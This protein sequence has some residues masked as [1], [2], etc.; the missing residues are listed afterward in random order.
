ML[1]KMARK[2]KPSTRKMEIDERLE[3]H[4][5]RI[6]EDINLVEERDERVEEVLLNLLSKFQ[7]FQDPRSLKSTNIDAMT[8][9]MDLYTSLPAKRAQLRKTII[10]T[11][12]KKQDL[13]QRKEESEDLKDTVSITMS[14][15][16]GM[17]EKS[18]NCFPSYEDDDQ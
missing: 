7:S 18:T 15:I 3:E 5:E 1:N 2:P 9:L 17:I 12:I 4:L 11:L 10:D 16:L 8:K 14:S 13:K 6:E